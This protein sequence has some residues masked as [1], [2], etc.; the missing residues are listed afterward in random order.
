MFSYVDGA[1]YRPLVVLAV[2]DPQVAVSIPGYLRDEAERLKAAPTNDRAARFAAALAADAGRSVRVEI[3]RPLFDAE[4]LTL[5][6]E[7]I[8]AGSGEAP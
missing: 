3:W 1:P 8:A 2:N 7:L 6:A 5:T 4:S